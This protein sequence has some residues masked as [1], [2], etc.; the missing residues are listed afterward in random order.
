MLCAEFVWS[1]S[2]CVRSIP[3]Q[4][5]VPPPDQCPDYY[6]VLTL[7]TVS[8][9][10]CPR[11]IGLW[12][13]FPF[14]VLCLREPWRLPPE[15]QGELTNYLDS[16][17]FL[18]KDFCH[19]TPVCVEGGSSKLH[20]LQ[21]KFQ[22]GL[23][24]FMYSRKDTLKDHIRGKHILPKHANIAQLIGV[25]PV[26]KLNSPWQPVTWTTTSSQP[27]THSEMLT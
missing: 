25:V 9:A 23:C 24:G 16:T 14:V 7:A 18:R 19:V 13:S 2:V 4:P 6:T 5:P 27:H 12:F 20:L 11:F 22:C 17:S 10:S 21:I 15:W 1:F 8:R 3:G 26:S